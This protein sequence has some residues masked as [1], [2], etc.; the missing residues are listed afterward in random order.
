MKELEKCLKALADKNRLRI[1]KLLQDR[2]MC[3]CELAQVIGITQP[4]VS[5]HL[6]KLK[7]AG[8]INSEQ[9]GFWTNYYV[10]TA[11]T[12]YGRIL[13]SNIREWLNDDAIIM[14]DKTE[15]GKADRTRICG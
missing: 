8:L 10:I 15:A 9:D 4:S 2:K 3:V 13:L 6:N 12:A 7:S 1:V 5:R 14:K 11:D